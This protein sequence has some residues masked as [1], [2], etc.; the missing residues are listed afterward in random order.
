MTA[1]AAM[2]IECDAMEYDVVVGP[3]ALTVLL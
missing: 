3:R 2:G 1:Q